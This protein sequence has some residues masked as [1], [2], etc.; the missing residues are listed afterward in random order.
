MSSRILKHSEA[1]LDLELSERVTLEQNLFHK[2]DYEIKI[3]CNSGLFFMFKCGI[4]FSESEK[5]CK[6]SILGK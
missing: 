1:F 4:F 2:G 5:Y 6:V 3:F